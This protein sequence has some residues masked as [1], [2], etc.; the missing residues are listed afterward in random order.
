MMLLSPHFLCISTSTVQTILFYS[1]AAKFRQLLL[2]VFVL[3]FVALRQAR[4]KYPRG[5]KH[6]NNFAS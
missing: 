5:K 2:F 6:L 1:V 3:L 4:Q